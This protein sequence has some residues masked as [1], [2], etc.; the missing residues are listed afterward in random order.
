MANKFEKFPF[1]EGW[2]FIEH[3][4]GGK[5]ILQTVRAFYDKDGW[6]FDNGEY[7]NTLEEMKD[8]EFCKID[9]PE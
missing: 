8:C 6:N 1:I 4:N 9:E 3:Y 7:I 2:Y 5:R